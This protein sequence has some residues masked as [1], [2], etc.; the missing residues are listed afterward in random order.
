MEKN[1]EIVCDSC[2]AKYSLEVLPSLRLYNMKCPECAGVCSVVNLSK[3]Y[4][5][6][7][8]AVDQSLLL[9]RTELGILHALHSEGRALFANDIAY[10][11]DCSYQLVGKR[12]K[13]LADRGLV[14][15]KENEA[16]RRTFSL[17]DVAEKNYFPRQDEGELKI[18]EE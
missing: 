3:R 2:G 9:P 1:Q 4:E 6:I 11:L 12:G 10:E 15:R 5:P 8:R 14:D 18:E 13:I 16:G 7:L 17:T